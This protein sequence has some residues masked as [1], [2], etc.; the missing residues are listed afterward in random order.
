MEN[1]MSRDLQMKLQWGGARNMS[2]L[3]AREPASD[4][5]SFPLR[6]VQEGEWVRIVSVSGGK[7]LHERL[8]GVGLRVGAE[9]QV[10][11]NSMNGKLL[12]GHQGA[13]LYLGG[14]MAHKIQVVVIQGGNR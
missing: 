10:L 12:L 1:I 13:R 9:V 7:G 3:L 11:Q 4:R 2:T 5:G 8:A 14:G 6:L